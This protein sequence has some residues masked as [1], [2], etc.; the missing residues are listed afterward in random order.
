MFC[1]WY[2]W[3]SIALVACTTSFSLILNPA[4]L[5]IFTTKELSSEDGISKLVDVSE[6]YTGSLL[7]V[8]YPQLGSN[9]FLT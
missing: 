5:H 8:L 6:L 9:G 4:N 1:F 7:I 2:V 3:P